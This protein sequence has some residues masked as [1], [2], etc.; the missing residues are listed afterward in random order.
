MLGNRFRDLAIEANSTFV[1]AA[2]FLVQ[3]VFLPVIVASE[4]SAFCWSSRCAMCHHGHTT[5]RFELFRDVKLEA[6]ANTRRRTSIDQ[7]AAA[8]LSLETCE[9]THVTLNTRTGTMRM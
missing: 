7:L 8:I 2:C 4:T 3:G 1:L 5:H 9:I 6:Y